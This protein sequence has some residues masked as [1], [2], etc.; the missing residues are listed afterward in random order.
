MEQSY[1]HV[2]FRPSVKL[3]STVRRFTEEFFRRMLD[4]REIAERVA[5]AT[6]EL[7]ENAVAYALDGETSVRVEMADDHLAVKTWNRASPERLVELGSMIDAMNRAGDPSAHYQQLFEKTA[8]RKDGSGLGL[9]RINAEA[10]MAVSYEVVA[11]DRVCIQARARIEPPRG[12]NA[13]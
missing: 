5:M 1:V 11:D 2:S 3:I 12:G 9:A 7:L 10:E 4:D 8:Y 6:H 13:T